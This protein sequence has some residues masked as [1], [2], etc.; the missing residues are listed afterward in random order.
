[1]ENNFDNTSDN[2]D[3]PKDAY[4]DPNAGTDAGQ[5]YTIR[6]RTQA[7]NI[8]AM[9]IRIS[10]ITT[11]RAVITIRI[12]TTIMWVIIQGITGPMTRAWIPAR[13]LWETGYLPFLPC[14]YLA[15][16]SCF[17][18]YGRLARTAM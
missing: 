1:M 12:I 6:T 2:N 10:S 15:R 11:S 17:I 4:S 7:S 18:L 13:C 3:M 16:A 14:A 9:R 5:S 8:T